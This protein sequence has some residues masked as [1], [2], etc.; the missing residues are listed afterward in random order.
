MLLRCALQG[1]E[2]SMDWFE[3]L[4]KNQSNTSIEMILWSEVQTLEDI[5]VVIDMVHLKAEKVK[6]I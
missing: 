4:S 2:M 3:S 5:Q 1:L 6:T